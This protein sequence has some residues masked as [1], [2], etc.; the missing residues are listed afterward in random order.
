VCGCSAMETNFMKIPTNSSCAVVASKVS[1]E[2][3][4]STEDMIF[5]CFS[6][7]LSHSVSLCGLPLCGWV[8][9]ASRRFHFTISALT[10]DRSSSSRAKIWQTDLLERWY[11]MMLPHRKSLS[12]SVKPF[13]CQ[14][15]SMEIAWR[16]AR[17][18]RAVSNG[19]GWNSQ[20]HSFEGV[21]PYFCIYSVPLGPKHK[22]LSNTTTFWMSFH[23]LLCH[24]LSYRA[25]I[26][27]RVCY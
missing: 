12:F 6:T 14:C 24:T 22:S 8:V 18:Y 5:T 10:V 1:L 16:C 25:C 7:R 3:S 19:C 4:V 15:L 27:Y 20:I 21:S 9:V 26:Q 23:Q 11:P 17:F 2:M 13:Y